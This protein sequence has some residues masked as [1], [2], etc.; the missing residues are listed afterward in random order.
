MFDVAMGGGLSFPMIRAS[1]VE[2]PDNGVFIF[3]SSNRMM[4]VGSISEQELF[5]FLPIDSMTLCDEINKRLGLAGSTGIDAY[6]YAARFTGSFGTGSNLMV[7]NGG[8]WPAVTSPQMMGCLRADSNTGGTYGP[9]NA[10]YFF[11]TI[12]LGR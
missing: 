10:R 1:Q 7:D 5:A 2:T 4:G 12:L 8:T 9:Y 6:I 3:Q 11:Y